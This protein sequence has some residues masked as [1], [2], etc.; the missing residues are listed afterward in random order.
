[1]TTDR[2]SSDT[3]T[4]G[5]V[6]TVSKIETPAASGHATVPP[7]PT[8]AR[9]ITWGPGSSAALSVV[10]F[11]LI[12]GAA[13]GFQHA[14]QK[15]AAREEATPRATMPTTRERST[16]SGVD[17]PGSSAP[18]VAMPVAAESQAPPPTIETTLAHARACAAAAR[19]SCVL[20]AANSVLAIQEGNPE[21]QSL[22]QRAIVQGGW[23][24][25]TSSSTYQAAAAPGTAATPVVKSHARRHWHTASR[26]KSPE[27][28][29]TA[30]DSS[31]DE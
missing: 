23:A 5:S 10:C 25:E 8:A 27:T 2:L 3:P 30:A 12:L 14:E 29:D 4:L 13:I 7:R 1:M 22:L 28:A 21:A 6:K 24:T 18:A 17:T 9:W 11:V 26:K 31:A 19:W 16:L 20:E 15:P